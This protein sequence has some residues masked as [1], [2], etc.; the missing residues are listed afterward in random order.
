MSD[1][2]P[3]R[4]TPNML[5]GVEEIGEAIGRAEAA[6]FAQDLRLR[7]ANRIRSVQGTLAIEGNRLSQDQVAA[8]LDGKPLAAPPREIQEARNAIQAYDRL[9]QWRPRSQT[10]LLDA[11]R[12]LM[13]ALLDA[14]GQ[15]R[16]GKV[17]V[18]GQE[19]IQHIAPSAPRVPQLMAALF[20]WLKETKEHPLIA[21]SVFHYEFEFIHPFEDGNGRL[22][23]LWQT[24]V[25]A[26]WRPLFAHIPVESLILARQADYYKAI[27]RS[28]AA[29]ESTAFIEFMLEVIAEA[30]L[31]PTASDQVGD[32]VALL[33]RALRNG[34]KTTAELMAG[35]GLKHRPSFRKNHL[36]PALL[37]GLVEMTHPESPTAKTQRYRLTRKGREAHRN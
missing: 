20:A 15:Y 33:L 4:I 37:A 14:P 26:R 2:P 8:I 22:G 5:A 18:A 11:H 23:R 6:G 32:Q 21:S 13:A 34:P 29:G 9:E 30:L 25:L 24:L 36:R 31:N 27:R 17:V 35:L 3:Y 19:G 12:I 7:R 28:S 16:R 1:Q 10:D